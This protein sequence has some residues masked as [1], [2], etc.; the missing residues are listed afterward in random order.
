[1]PEN[2]LS[3]LKKDLKK[4]K[5]QALLI[6]VLQSDLDSWSDQG[7]DVFRTVYDTCS[8]VFDSDVKKGKTNVLVVDEGDCQEPTSIFRSLLGSLDHEFDDIHKREILA[9]LT[10]FGLNQAFGSAVGSA[11][12]DSLSVGAE[13]MMEYVAEWS[14]SA[15]ESVASIYEAGVDAVVDGSASVLETIGETSAEAITG[16][17]CS[18]DEM[19]LSRPAR[20]RLKELAPRLS[21][22]ATSHES[23]QLALEMLLVTAQGAPK[24]IVVRDPLLLDDASLALLAM[25]VSQEKDVRQS[26]PPEEPGQSKAT[27]TAGISVVLTFSGPQPHD[28]VSN[29][30]T[31]EKQR[32][33]LRLRMMASRYSLLERLDSDIPAP[34]VRASTFVGREYE[35]KSLWQNWDTLCK[36]PENSAKQTWALIKGEPGTGKTAL[37]NEFI[38]QIRSDSNNP[39]HL[40]VP[41]LR[42]LNQ[43]G[44]NANATGLASFKNSIV[45]ELRRLTLIYSENV[46]WFARL[47]KQVTE[48][49]QSWTKDATS[50]DPGAKER[51]Q[52]RIRRLV[53]KLIGV[54]AAVDVATS[55]KAW[56]TQN[57]MFRMREEEFG[58]SP[59][60]DQKEEQFELLQEALKEIRVLTCKCMPHQEGKTTENT[61][62]LLLLV[63]D[64]QWIDDLTAEFLLNEWAKDMPVYIIATARGSD[65][66][67]VSGDSRT[68]QAL[69]RH[70]NQL[71]SELS[72]IGAG[73]VEPEGAPGIGRES[74]KD[75]QKK[76]QVRSL[77][78]AGCLALKGMDQ[79]ML[80]NLLVLTYA[81]LTK[82]HAEQFAASVIQNLSDDNN[83]SDVVTLFVIETLNVISDPRFYQR[84]PGLPRLIEPLPGTDRYCFKNPQSVGL[85]DA[86]AEVFKNLKA[87]YQASYLIESSQGLAGGCF[88][89]PSYAILEERLHL[90]EQYFSNYAGTVRYSLI[91]SAIIGSPF[92]SE[93]IQYII[94]KLKELFDQGYF[95]VK[96]FV[97]D[98]RERSFGRLQTYQYE[99]LESAYEIIKK[100]K[101]R[102]RSDCFYMHQHG[103]IKQYLVAKFSGI[104]TSDCLDNCDAELAF[105]EVI[106]SIKLIGNDWFSKEIELSLGDFPSQE[107]IEI[108]R[109]RF[110]VSVVG[111]VY[112]FKLSR[113]KVYSDWAREYD[114]WLTQLAIKMR[115]HGCV[116]EALNLC[117]R[118]FSICSEG[119]SKYPEFWAKEYVR[120]LNNMAGTYSELGCLKEATPL[121]EEVLSI[122]QA[123]HLKQPRVWASYY[124]GVLNN[125]ATTYYELGR[126]KESLDFSRE[127]L[128]ILTRYSHGVMPEKWAELYS[129]ILRNISGI[130]V[131]LGDYDEALFSAEEAIFACKEYYDS[132]YL[133]WGKTYSHCLIKLAGAYLEKDDAEKALVFIDDALSI[134]RSGYK[135]NPSAWVKY[136][137]EG[138]GEK[139]RALQKIGDKQGALQYFEDN[140]LIISEEY[141]ENPGQWSETYADTLSFL[142]DF[143]YKLGS[144]EKTIDLGLVAIPI[145]R[146]GYRIAPDRW[147]TNYILTLRNVAGSYERLKQ[148]VNA[149]PMHREAMVI[150]RKMFMLSPYSSDKSYVDC[151]NSV[152]RCYIFNREY[153][154]A[155]NIINIS[156]RICKENHGKVLNEWTSRHM[157]STFLKASIYSSLG[158]FQSA[159]GSQVAAASIADFGYKAD[160]K[161]WARDY[162]YILLQMSDILLSLGK[163]RESSLVFKS[164]RK[165]IEEKS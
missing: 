77:S 12:T 73:P 160:P 125:L 7:S 43:T 69:N 41:I 46:G 89:L 31:A 104:F 80:A 94:D 36:Q 65:S 21:K 139:A 82:E 28:T 53:S 25:L 47:G 38:R 16:Q 127:A 129:I 13:K 136:L 121:K 2:R 57:E 5:Q 95:D 70:R 79:P 76:E 84:N 112:D 67:T 132:D 152:V 59:R 44:H 154:K 19:Y 88:N 62:P 92:S 35:L 100:V 140:R 148:H 68:H 163:K 157:W 108:E 60:A 22:K 18:D 78:L 143:Y 72:L 49:V 156:V 10:G 123:M 50:D 85:A 133:L 74:G 142:G 122:A 126:V 149:L 63:D 15:S 138:L 98:L 87:T 61:P 165:L 91:L 150:C 20:M 151:I 66:F 134:Q 4:A 26:F 162:G 164:A 130:Y 114:Y 29:K 90:I 124:A 117:Q 30:D 115:S 96:I 56:S 39:A 45:D 111:C 119:Y 42:I 93:L 3:N 144:F 52:V 51:T 9:K 102:A 146:S 37:A 128:M 40:C 137:V 97:D 159:L 17:F 105:E 32:A 106:N 109:L 110:L 155:K 81:G 161:R 145:H 34:A 1:M 135:S 141:N 64:L 14:G 55:S 131:D 27:K 83:A 99:V 116:S 113:D 147:A 33:I 24:V 103:L 11:V 120:S 86:T 48:G 153:L 107:S 71:F 6:E 118:S 101:E 158:D 58:Q 75:Q 8:A 23:L 54:D